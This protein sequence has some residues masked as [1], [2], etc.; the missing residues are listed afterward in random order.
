MEDG[1]GL[2]PVR[3]LLHGGKTL[4]VA[5]RFIHGSLGRDITTTCEPWMLQGIHSEARLLY[6]FPVESGI[7]RIAILIKLGDNRAIFLPTIR[8]PNLS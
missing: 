3:D 8:D 5:L 7:V 1:C 2:S 4:A 6:R